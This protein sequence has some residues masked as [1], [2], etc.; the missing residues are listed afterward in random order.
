MRC[1]YATPLSR[2]QRDSNPQCS[3][4]ATPVLE[5]G[6]LPIRLYCH[7]F[8]SRRWLDLNQHTGHPATHGLANRC[9]TKLGLQRHS[10]PTKGVRQEFRKEF[11]STT[12]KGLEP[13]SRFTATLA[14]Q[15]SLLPIRV[16]CHTKPAKRVRQGFLQKSRSISATGLE[17]AVYGLEDRCILPL[18]YADIASP[19]LLER[20]LSGS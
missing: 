13:S 11:R 4:P 8:L 3:F 1:H 5:A 19:E 6:A 20:P 14:F 10:K 2:Q 12:A 9:L 17:P 7:Y 15:A 18:C 16:R